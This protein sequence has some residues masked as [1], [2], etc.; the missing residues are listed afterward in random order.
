MIFRIITKRFHDCLKATKNETPIEEIVNMNDWELIHNIWAY[1]RL[2]LFNY[3][4]MTNPNSGEE[5]FKKLIFQEYG[6]YF[7]RKQINIY[8]DTNQK[9]KKVLDISVA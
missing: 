1:E 7:G 9:V 5:K 4:R 2:T 3:L 6:Y 8:N